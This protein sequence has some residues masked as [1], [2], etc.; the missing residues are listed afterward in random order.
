MINSNAPDF[1][2]TPIHPQRVRYPYHPATPAPDPVVS[3]VTPI[4]NMAPDLFAET[5]QSIRGQSLQAWTWL[6]VNDGSTNPDTLA[7]LDSLPRLDPR[8][9]VLHVPQNRNQAYAR[10]TGCAVAP[11]EF[12]VL[13]DA[14]DLLEP[15]A[16]ETWYWFLLSHP[17]CSFTRSYSVRFDENPHLWT[18]SFEAGPAFLLRNQ[19]EQ[20]AMIRRSVWEAVDGFDVRAWQGL[21][22]WD[23]WLRC[24]AAGFWGATV[25]EFLQWYRQRPHQSRRWTVMRTEA[26]M[27]GY[28]DIL[29][30]KYKHLYDGAFPR[31]ER[32]DAPG[33]VS[34]A[35]PSH[36][37]LTKDNLRAL[38]LSSHADAQTYEAI[39]QIASQ[40]YEVSVCV[41]ES[42]DIAALTQL[43]PD[44][45]CL[46][47]FLRPHDFPR[48]LRYLAESRQV[49]VL[50][51]GGAYQLLPFWQAIRPQMA[52]LGFGS[53][54]AAVTPS[55]PEAGINEIQAQFTAT[56]AVATYI[57]THGTFDRTE[58]VNISDLS[59][60]TL[61]GVLSMRQLIKALLFKLIDRRGLRWLYVYRAVAKWLLGG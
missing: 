39:Q 34:I 60:E 5:V 29:R 6:I 49:D 56:Y 37:P 23:F 57:L 51:T 16:I 11:T 43:T 28:R 40:G 26:S 24:A 52:R 14:D 18:S 19:C 41:T 27:F 33:A 22:D 48:F 50:L 20:T 38:V 1:T 36:N 10:N 4:Y 21:E 47:H 31:V 32:N 3:I 13:I 54:P 58:P 17:A 15:T 61:S 25:P 9:R 12:V 35:V 53:L 45:F 42:S 7:Y 8:I 46:P 44:V 30:Q 59:G 55:Q 2:L